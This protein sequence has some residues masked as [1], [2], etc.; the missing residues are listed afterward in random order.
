MT[1]DDFWSVIDE[2][3]SD[4]L[5]SIDARLRAM[6]DREYVFFYKMLCDYI[7]RAYSHDLWGVEF[8]MNGGCGDDSFSDFRVWLVFQGREIYEAALRDP[9]SLAAYWKCSEEDWGQG[10]YLWSTVCDAGKEPEDVEQYPSR[11]IAGT[12]WEEDDL[13]TRF[14]KTWAAFDEEPGDEELES[15]EPMKP[16]KG[17]RKAMDQI[18]RLDP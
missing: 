5:A 3:D 17:L 2:V 16:V 4:S 6:S 9:D 15:M 7:H 10:E 18:P 8:I 11:E 12:P 1:E 14:P 13:P